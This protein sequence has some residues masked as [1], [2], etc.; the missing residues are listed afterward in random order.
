MDTQY[1]V[2]NNYHHQPVDMTNFLII[3]FRER[4][5]L[6]SRVHDPS[7][8]TSSGKSS[9]QA[10]SFLDKSTQELNSAIPSFIS[11]LNITLEEDVPVAFSSDSLYMLERLEINDRHLFYDSL[12]NKV[13]AK[14]SFIHSEGIAHV[15]WAAAHAEIWDK[16]LWKL[17]Q[18]EIENRNLKPSY[19]VNARWS[20]NYFKDQ[21]HSEHDF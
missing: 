17:I 5:V 21:T 4:L 7:N 8:I 1:K 6:S 20:T 19:V 11:L 12:V 15:A 16:D 14:W 2:S 18:S 13:K 9:S 10:A 3:K